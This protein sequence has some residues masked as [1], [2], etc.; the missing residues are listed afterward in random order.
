MIGPSQTRTA[1]RS[2]PTSE[3]IGLHS[4]VLALPHDSGYRRRVVV[5][6]RCYQVSV[7]GT[8]PMGKEARSELVDEL[9]ER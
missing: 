5:S 6:A 7:Q 4:R 9:Q 1:R 3:V 2:V 8:K